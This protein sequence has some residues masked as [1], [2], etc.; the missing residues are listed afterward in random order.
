M[1]RSTDESLEIATKH[2][3]TAVSGLTIKNTNTMKKLMIAA[4]L[5]FACM[6]A[7]A[8]TTNG[9]VTIVKE[10]KTFTATKAGGKSGSGYQP[11]GYTYI[12]TDG[13]A[14]E[15]HTHEI[16]KGKNQGKT[17]CYIQRVSKT[18]GKNYWKE[19]AVKPEELKG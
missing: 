2:G 4:V 15:I 3:D 11:T 18:S 9:N 16:T 6:T 1:E 17:K 12:D 13:N 5:F 7:Q 19:I 14:Y 8:Q 10:G